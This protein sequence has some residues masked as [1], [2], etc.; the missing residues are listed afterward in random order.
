MGEIESPVALSSQGAP[1]WLTGQQLDWNISAGSFGRNCRR[2]CYRL[3][4]L[5]P[6][7]AVRRHRFPNWNMMCPRRPH[8]G[9]L[10][11]RSWRRL[12]TPRLGHPPGERRYPARHRRGL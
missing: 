10:C 3:R 12:G 6:Y 5:W 8:H 11:C 7:C 2:K 9:L 4:D 1:I